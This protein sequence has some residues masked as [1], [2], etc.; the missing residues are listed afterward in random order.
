MSTFKTRL[1]SLRHPEF[2]AVTQQEFGVG[3]APLVGSNL[4]GQPSATSF[5]SAPFSSA[6]AAPAAAPTVWRVPA[7]LVSVPPSAVPM[8]EASAPLFPNEPEWNRPLSAPPQ[9]NRSPEP[10]AVSLQAVAA[11]QMAPAAIP[12]SPLP[13]APFSTPPTPEVP[14]SDHIQQETALSG[15]SPVAPRPDEPP[16]Q[17]ADTAQFQAL[18]DAAFPSPQELLTRAE[19]VNPASAST[20]PTDPQDSPAAADVPTRSTPRRATFREVMALNDL[21]Q[22]EP[23]AA[24]IAPVPQET[25]QA[26][27]ANSDSDSAPASVPVQA[28]PIEIAPVQ[29]V[30]PQEAAPLLAA[31]LAAPAASLAPDATE[32]TE[33]QTAAAVQPFATS[34]DMAPPT[35]AQAPEGQ[36]EAPSDQAELR[37]VST[38]QVNVDPSPAAASPAPAS[39]P[40]VV[41]PDALTQGAGSRTPAITTDT[42][43]SASAAPAQAEQPETSEP[44]VEAAQTVEVAPEEP[45]ISAEAVG[46]Q[47]ATPTEQRLKAD[48]LKAIEAIMRGGDLDIG[49]ILPRR[50][51]P[52]RR[53]AAEADA[54]SPASP[55]PRAPTAP[56]FEELPHAEVMS[57]F[58]RLNR[59]ADAEEEG[60]TETRMLSFEELTT[61]QLRRAPAAPNPPSPVQKATGPSGASTPTPPL[62]ATVPSAA[63]AAASRFR[64]TARPRA[65]GQAT[66][67]PPAGSGPIPASPGQTA[68]EPQARSQ[69]ADQSDEEGHSSAPPVELAGLPLAPRNVGMAE[70][71]NPGQ[72]QPEAPV[73]NMDRPDVDQTRSGATPTQLSDPVNDASSA[74]QVT[75]QEPQPGPQP[76]P[77]GALPTAQARAAAKTAEQEAAPEPLTQAPA[78]LTIDAASDTLSSVNL[79]STELL[80]AATRPLPAAQI[81][82]GETLSVAAPTLPTVAAPAGATSLGLVQ[83]RGESAETLP[84]ALL[85]DVQSS[86]ALPLSVSLV[87]RP[88]PTESRTLAD[89]Q[90]QPTA[91]NASAGVEPELASLPLPFVQGSLPDL[92]QNDAAHE[93]TQAVRGVSIIPAASSALQA[94][95]TLPIARTSNTPSDLPSVHTPSLMPL[96]APMLEPSLPTPTFPAP[97][98]Q[99]VSVPQANIAARLIPGSSSSAAARFPEA[100]DVGMVPVTQ[101]SALGLA[102]ATPVGHSN[103][104]VVVQTIPAIQRQAVE[105][106]QVRV[107]PTEGQTS[108]LLPEAMQSAIVNQEPTGQEAPWAPVFPDPFGQVMVPPADA[109]PALPTP[110]SSGPLALQ[111]MPA[112]LPSLFAFP[113]IAPMPHLSGPLSVGPIPP[114][115]GQVQPSRVLPSQTLQQVAITNLNSGNPSAGNLILPP[116]PSVNVEGMRLA[117]TG[118]TSSL[119][120]AAL[121]ATSLSAAAFSLTLPSGILPL[122]APTVPLTTPAAAVSVLAPSVQPEATSS[123]LPAALPATSL[124]TAA[125]SPTFPPARLP[126]SAPTAPLA[127]PAA[128]V[129]ILAPSVQPEAT[130]SLL[131]A[132]LPATS[133]PTAAFSPTF[134]PARLPLSAPTA[135]LVTPAAAVSVLAPSVQPEA[136]SSLLPAALPATSLPAAALS[137]TFPPARLPL[138]ALTAPL[139]RPAAAVSVLAPSVSRQMANA[140]GVRVNDIPVVQH[141]G[142]QPILNQ[143]R[144]EA[145]TIG[146]IVIL[147]PNVDLRSPSGLGV[148]AHE[149]THALRARRPDFVPQLVQATPNRNARAS[150]LGEEALALHV[151]G[152]VRASARAQGQPSL[153]NRSET[154]VHSLGVSPSSSPAV[155]ATRPRPVSAA[156]PRPASTGFTPAAAPNTA[157]PARLP[158]PWEP[159]PFWED[160]SSQAPAAAPTFQPNALPAAPPP[161]AS[162]SSGPAPIYA[163]STD[164]Q[165]TEPAPP[166]PALPSPSPSAAPTSSP[167]SSPVAATSRQPSKAQQTDLDL[168]AQ[169]VYGVLRRRLETEMRRRT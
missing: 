86:G 168:L 128:A 165:V 9:A 95:P 67:T 43:S 38:P 145:L 96:P 65:D 46:A 55:S 56:A 141:A 125:F 20:L 117:Q 57:V 102:T 87:P 151:E 54:G 68:R 104:A 164:R 148:L 2:L 58:D 143:H 89:E 8:P 134:P 107:Q 85:P 28:A 15:A 103:L 161:A 144:A 153:Q 19:A 152:A 40:S 99:A 62:P 1:D 142:T 59:M 35:P 76:V 30:P 49:V 51:R 21:A 50:P 6:P 3:P 42:D 24:P 16:T 7:R 139:A 27:S 121:P 11:S 154:P 113:G 146:D 32:V 135:L 31:A 130:S 79:S 111:P 17:T 140:L 63:P 44:Q 14:F 131:P 72:G 123:L 13:V 138:S 167:S 10:E 48:E 5:S 92:S 90:T 84:V 91:T 60:T 36:P 83:E 166:P 149:L 159:M 163:A 137:P 100:R 97:V 41:A 147:G 126:L 71:M 116:L 22:P 61:G 77:E 29:P 158:A 66:S 93:L 25:S 129:S 127:T 82:D 124:P 73:P 101:P 47:P 94:P 81:T 122:S 155:Q 136:T 45:P 169:Q 133:L 162:P 37:E 157:A 160:S 115:L 112:S 78:S 109:P 53:P 132:A 119:L 33:P 88:V 74:V 23:E 4:A 150:S 64:A 106:R 105:A 98:P 18:T 69:T 34:A 26:G 12:I 75:E 114:Q 110:Y 52:T 70:A 156:P 120:V 39:P 80:A 118:V 108:E